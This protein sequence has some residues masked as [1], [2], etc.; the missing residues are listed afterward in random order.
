MGMDRALLV[1]RSITYAYK[2]QRLL[3]NHGIYSQVIRTP[4]EYA[5]SG[6]SYSLS[7]ARQGTR[8]AN[9]LRYSGIKLL[10]VVRNA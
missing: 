10:K 1:L 3:E 2:A 5:P 6:C 4:A 8:A 7:V 9:I